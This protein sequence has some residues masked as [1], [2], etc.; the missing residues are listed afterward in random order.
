MSGVPEEIKVQGDNIEVFLDRVIEKAKEGF[1]RVDGM[2]LSLSVQTNYWSMT[3]RRE[4]Q[5][6]E[7]EQ[8]EQEVKKTAGRPAKVKQ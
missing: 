1:V 4:V 8:E 6:E 7:Q 5:E 3:M 2:E